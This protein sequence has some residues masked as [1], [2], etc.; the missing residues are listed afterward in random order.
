M[1]RGFIG[2]AIGL[3]IPLCM[4]QS[5][6]S[7]FLNAVVDGINDGLD[8]GTDNDDDVTVTPT[9]IPAGVY[10]PT[11]GT[12][13]ETMDNLSDA[14]P[15]DTFTTTLTGDLTFNS[16][17]YLLRSANAPLAIGD[18]ITT[19]TEWGQ[20]QE[21]VS[22]VL[23]GTNVIRYAT[24]AAMTLAGQAGLSWHFAGTGL[25]TFRYSGGT[26]TY[27]GTLDLVSD[28]A[29]GAQYELTVEF[30]NVTLTK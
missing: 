17:G 24:D 20:V 25:R 9:G 5:C 18:T 2:L 1:R 29:G 28:V 26:L 23:P 13:V 16:N 6:S 10:S 8:D 3:A 7:A 19:D 14:N 4:G 15:P 22:G 11:A 21:V 30:N 27:S 12:V